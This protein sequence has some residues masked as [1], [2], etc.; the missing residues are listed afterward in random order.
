MTNRVRGRYV[1]LD[2]FCGDTDEYSG[3]DEEDGCGR[4]YSEYCTCDACMNAEDETP[5]YKLKLKEPDDD[6][7]TMP[8]RDEFGDDHNPTVVDAKSYAGEA[9][10]CKDCGL[11]VR[12]PADMKELPCDPDRYGEPTKPFE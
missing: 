3:D 5:V 12:L 10:E 7:V 9:F 2:D 4:G 1:A 8:D 6:D 11:R